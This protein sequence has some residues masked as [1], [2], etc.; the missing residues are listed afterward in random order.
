[1]IGQVTPPMAIALIISG[2][3]AGVD[4]MRVFGANWPF[5]IGMVVFLLILIGIPG[6]ATYLPSLLRS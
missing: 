6:I 2:R 1:V 3:I 4:Q 5:L